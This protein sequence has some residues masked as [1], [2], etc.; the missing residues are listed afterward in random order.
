MGRSLQQWGGIA[1][2]LAIACAATPLSAVGGG[3]P[4][5][6]PAATPASVADAVATALRANPALAE[7]VRGSVTLY[8]NGAEI[9]ATAMLADAARAT[10]R[11]R[12]SKPRVL[13]DR[14]A[15][16]GENIV[17]KGMVVRGA[18]DTPVRLTATVTMPGAA[19]VTVS[20]DIVVRARPRALPP[21]SAYLFVYFTGNSIEGEKL[22]FAVS[23]GNDALR[24]KTLNDAQPVLESTMGTRGLRDPFIMRSAEGDRFFLLATDLSTGRTGWD[25]ATD[26]GSRHLEVWES[27]DLVH[28]GAQRHVEVNLPN[29][30]MTWAP[31]AT[32]DPTIQAYVVYWTSTLF[33]DA[34]R[35]Q[36]DGNGPQILMS[37]TR[38]FRTFTTPR[39][40]FKA[41]DRPELVPASG[42]IDT[43]VLK[44]GNY[45][46]RFTK[47]TQAKGC[48]SADI[49]AERSTS[50]RAT[51]ASGA[52]SVVG[53]C[54]GRSSGTPEV[55]GP[56]AFV[57]NPNDR[58]GF[59]YY[60]WVDDYGGVG[61]IPLATNALGSQVTWTYPRDFDLPASPRHGSVLSI[62]AAE[63]DV[64][65]AKWKPA[66]GAAGTAQGPNAR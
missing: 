36:G 61:Y 66:S 55:E 9:P 25:G 57:A 22:R 15:G 27:T 20:R 23:D 51:V 64:L 17:R 56:S 53:R 38:D 48:K 41:A 54:V 34:S 60:L 65:T 16:S 35:K 50:L 32:Y 6:S 37:T 5:A 1:A 40:W 14:D 43:T 24:W 28:W 29:A 19:P 3:G 13:S 30:G 7:P 10:I 45:Y 49:Y 42:M 39:P 46:Y 44:D 26:R 21:M 52:W 31:E 12:S 4:V 8:D 33:A 63:R 47:V 62:T 11:W 18:A 59:R 2:A 58:S